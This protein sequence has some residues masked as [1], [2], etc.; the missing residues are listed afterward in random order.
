MWVCVIFLGKKQENKTP[1]SNEIVD[2]KC[3]AGGVFMRKRNCRGMKW[4]RD[5]RKEGNLTMF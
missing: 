3:P 5:G 4:S 2:R 1:G